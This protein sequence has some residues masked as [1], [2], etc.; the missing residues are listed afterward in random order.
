[1][2]F[3]FVPLLPDFYD[4]FTGAASLDDG[5]DVAFRGALERE[6]LDFSLDSLHAVDE[7]LAV[8]HSKVAELEEQVWDQTVVCAGAYLGEVIVRNSSKGHRWVSYDDYIV[9][10]PEMASLLPR[11]LPLEAVLVN[12]TGV[13]S[14]PLNKIA[15]FIEQGA[16]HNTHFFALAELRSTPEN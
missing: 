7:Y 2:A 10:H 4:V 14:L 16:E 12:E 11:S 1:M 3:D 8:V 15:R 5:D 9:L 6:R 13:L